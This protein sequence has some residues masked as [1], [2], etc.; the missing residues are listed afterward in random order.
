MGKLAAAAI[1]F[2][3]GLILGM[4][5]KNKRIALAH[6]QSVHTLDFKLWTVAA[7]VLAMAFITVGTK[8]P[9]LTHI[10]FGFGAAFLGIGFVWGLS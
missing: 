10:G 1:G 2:L 7:F 3:G 5:I 6:A 4:F 8:W 9:A